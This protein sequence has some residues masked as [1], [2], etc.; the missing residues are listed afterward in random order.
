VLGLRRIGANAVNDEILDAVDRLD[1][2]MEKVLLCMFRQEE[3]SGKTG[4]FHF[5]LMERIASKMLRLMEYNLV[6]IR[7]TGADRRVAIITPQGREAAG[8]FLAQQEVR[9]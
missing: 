3:G 7:P 8:Y 2:G 9:S 4:V 1:P 5:S 6:R